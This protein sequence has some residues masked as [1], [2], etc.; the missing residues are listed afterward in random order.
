MLLETVDDVDALVAE[1][2]WSMSSF[3][4]SFVNLVCVDVASSVG[5]SPSSVV[6]RGRGVTDTGC[7]DCVI[8]VPAYSILG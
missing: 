1:A 2:G 3:I 5:A 4:Q 7:R 8:D 6:T